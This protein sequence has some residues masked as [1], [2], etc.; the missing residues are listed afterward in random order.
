[1]KKQHF[2][3]LLVCLAFFVSG[4]SLLFSQQT[5]GCPGCTVSSDPGENWGFCTVCEVEGGDVCTSIGPGPSCDGN[6]D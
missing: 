4:S 3:A 5:L 2:Y 1:M 6:Q